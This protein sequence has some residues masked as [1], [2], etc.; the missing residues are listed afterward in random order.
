LLRAERSGTIDYI[1]GGSRVNQQ[2]IDLVANRRQ[3]GADCI[4]KRRS[5]AA[6]RKEDSSLLMR[7]Q[8]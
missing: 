3:G 4:R 7:D 5:I 6:G 1:R 8:D 2:N